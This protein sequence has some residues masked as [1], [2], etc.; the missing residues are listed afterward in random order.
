MN[1]TGFFKFI[2]KKLIKM[3]KYAL[4]LIRTLHLFFLTLYFIIT[5]VVKNAT[6]FINKMIF[7][8]TKTA[9]KLCLK[10]F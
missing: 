6:I 8:K 4:I 9:K 7:L 1:R 5:K 3:R 10:N 2:K